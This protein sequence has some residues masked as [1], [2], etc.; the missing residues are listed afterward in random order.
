LQD[1]GRAVIVGDSS[2]F[3]KGT[4]QNLLPLSLVMDRAGITHTYDPGAL[5]LTI[6]KFYRPDGASTQ[7]RGV[8]S[9]IVLPSPSDISDVNE[10]ALKNP[11]PWD[12][13]PATLHERLNRVEPYLGTLRER[14]VQRIKTDRDFAYLAEDVAR[15]KKSV[16]E[17]S[18]S[19]NEA[20]RRQELAQIKARKG[21]REREERTHP[22]SRPTTY[23]ITL[24]NAS[25][26]GLP[27]PLASTKSQPLARDGKPA[28][29]AEDLDQIAT[30][31]SPQNDVLLKET[32]RILADYVDLLAGKH[33]RRQQAGP[34]QSEGALCSDR[35][36]MG[37][38]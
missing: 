34:R 12:A 29:P 22:T 24:K 35:C 9:D 32:T 13:V 27:P 14:S 5:K 19:L 21:E 10:S 20:E 7:L 23:E 11:L 2:T 31:H 38:H 8:A 16:S 26:S 3:G 28:S 37:L 30:G 6:S 1:Y 33:E 15:F 4:V 25:L 18:V 17:K 36:P